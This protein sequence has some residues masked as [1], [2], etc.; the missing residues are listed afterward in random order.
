VELNAW[1]GPSFSRVIPVKKLRVT[2]HVNLAKV[3]WPVVALISFL[4]R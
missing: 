3:L 4:I 1:A 2:V